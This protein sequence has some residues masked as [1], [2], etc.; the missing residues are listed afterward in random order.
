MGQTDRTLPLTR[1]GG[2]SHCRR[3]LILNRIEYVMVSLG[4]WMAS[5]E[6]VTVSSLVRHIPLKL[7]RKGGS[8]GGNKFR[9]PLG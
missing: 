8:C 4:V 6:E 9:V 3:Y 5:E 7:K 1:Q 2:V